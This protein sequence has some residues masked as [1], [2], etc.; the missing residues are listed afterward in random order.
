MDETLIYRK[1]NSIPAMLCDDIKEIFHKFDYAQHAGST[2]SGVKKDI[3]NTT[4]LDLMKLDTDNDGSMQVGKI[5]EFLLGELQENICTYMKLFEELYPFDSGGLSECEKFFV[6]TLQ[7]QMY[8]KNVGHYVYHHDS[9]SDIKMERR[10]TFMW[11][12]N[13]IDIGGETEFWGN[14][15]IIPKRGMLVLFPATWTHIHRA[16]V[17]ISDDKYIITGWFCYEHSQCGK[18]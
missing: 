12:L 11:Y 2:G 17:P 13:D 16:C 3:K 18:T 14:V 5:I 6:D 7:I 10:M 1:K 9:K 4:D 8:K 15:K